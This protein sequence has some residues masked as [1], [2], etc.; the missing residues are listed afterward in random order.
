VD[1][2]PENKAERPRLSSSSPLDRREL[3]WA[4]LLAALGLL[5]RLLFVARYPTQPYSDFRQLISFGQA[6][7]ESLIAKTWLWE[8]FN[9]GLP[10]ALS[11]LFSL[12]P[13]H[14]DTV[15]RLGTAVLCGLLGLLPFLL[16]R[17]VLPF[18]VRFLAGLALALWPG[19][20][21]F[22]GVVAQD[23]WVLLPTV[24]L[25]CLA[26][27][28]L[29]DGSGRLAPVMAGVLFVLALVTRQEM[30]VTLFPVAVAATG[31]WT[32]GAS[33]SW[34][35]G[36]AWHLRRL[37]AF[38]AAAGLFLLLFATQRYLATGRFTVLT[39]H[40]G[41]TVLSAYIP[42]A[43][44]NNWADPVAY[45]ATVRPDLVLDRARLQ[46]EALGLTLD[47]ALRR[48]GFHALR[49]ASCLLR[50]SIDGEKDNLFWAL[51]PEVQLPQNQERSLA[52]AAWLGPFLRWEM[53]AI[54]AFFLG[55]LFLGILTRNGPIL[56]LSSFVVLKVVLHAVTMAQGRYFLSVTAVGILVLVLG[57][58]EARRATSRH[59]VRWSYGLGTALAATTFLLTTPVVDR[60]HALD[61]VS[62]RTYQFALIEPRSHRVALDCRI[63]KGEL[64]LLESSRFLIQPFEADPPPGEITE[65]VCA[66]QPTVPFRLLIHDGYA[67]GGFPDRIRQ[68]VELD[69]VELWSHD[70]AAEPGDG[71]TEVDLGTGLPGNPKN[72]RKVR[73]QVVAVRPDPGP[74]WGRAA[75]TEIQ[76]VG[77]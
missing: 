40:T 22:S 7:H 12:V 9:P 54:L 46:K 75:L 17:G 33:R 26:V 69:G 76:V 63:E 6:L 3:A 10:T 57:L 43:T 42:G 67:P 25:A 44:A 56:V 39:K 68:R 38:A 23:N 8:F 58:W 55:A 30:L 59:A 21:A 5:P 77:R 65:A 61:T 29:Y 45:A 53:A 27:R 19:Q 49:I 60:V 15:A 41:T 11:L 72:P 14:H 52:L 32:V 71:W 66:V 34:R 35:E 73:I 64:P 36:H 1:D 37:A 50:F 70:L 2:I 62:Q 51:F 13:G 28:A 24:A 16:W 4:A 74:A 20:I 48:P 31:F 47:E 18:R